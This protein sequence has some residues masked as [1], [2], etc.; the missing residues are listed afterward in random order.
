MNNNIGKIASVR[1]GNVIGGGDFSEARLVPDIVKALSN[2]ESPII[3][4]PNSIRP[5]QHVLDPL[6]GYM[7]VA[8]TLYNNEVNQ[9]KNMSWN[10]GPDYSDEAEVNKV[11]NIICSLW[12]NNLSPKVILDNSLHEA[13]LLTLDSSKA[14]KEL[15]WIPKWRLE[16]ALEKTVDWYKC[17]YHDNRLISSLT[18]KQI[19]D[20]FN[21]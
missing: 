5:W 16:Q 21:L 13:K 12:Q 19:E 3:R 14:R 18:I 4:N 17:F 15:H 6:S 20:Y 1:A 2:N 11:A 7:K 8:E 10:F 9:E